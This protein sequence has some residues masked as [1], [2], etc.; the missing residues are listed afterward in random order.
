MSELA[1][2]QKQLKLMQ[3]SFGSR[4]GQVEQENTELKRRCEM[5]EDANSAFERKINYLE[6][7]NRNKD[8]NY[9]LTIPSVDQLL[10]RVEDM[11]E[12]DA[13]DIIELMNDMKRET[14][15]MRSLSKLV[16]IVP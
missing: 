8:W 10:A 9:P 3:Q 4:L 11:D 14:T 13:D 16:P 5:L 12:T 2:L 15:K 6:F 7:V 1:Q